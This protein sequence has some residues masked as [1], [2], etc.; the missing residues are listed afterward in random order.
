MADKHCKSGDKNERD[1][2]FE[3]PPSE[4]V[5]KHNCAR[6]QSSEFDL[7]FEYC[8]R[9]GL[10]PIRGQV[11]PLV[12]NK[13]DPT[14]R[15]M[16]IVV[17]V[18]GQ[19]T[20]AARLGDYRP[21]ENEPSY[22]YD[23]NLKGDTN[24]LGIVKCSV[25]VWKQDKA[26]NWFKVNGVAYWD[27]FAAI[28]KW[29]DKPAYLDGLW[30]TKPRIMI[31]KCAESQALRKGWP[32]Q[33]ANVYSDAE[34]DHKVTEDRNASAIVDEYNQKQR[35]K[36][37]GGKRVIPLILDDETGIER[38]PVGQAADRYLSVARKCSDLLAFN[39][40]ESRNRESLREFWAV[41]KPDALELRREL[42]II[43]KTLKD[44]AYQVNNADVAE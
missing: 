34:F 18:D 40:L 11:I 1:C 28:K 44:D 30:G 5:K 27:E 41:S 25:T 12:F 6:L 7:F 20:I 31:A 42:E 38:V 23:E 21:D 22:T 13:N 29:G 39:H 26:A 15:K 3:R 16:N 2:N 17:T 37:I 33:F 35:F 43:E 10:D 32:D 24:P 8:N 19:R 4:H 14:K 9:V 36:M